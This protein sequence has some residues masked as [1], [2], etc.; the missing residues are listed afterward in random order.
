MKKSNDISI[1]KI[2][3]SVNKAISDNITNNHSEID[4]GK[5]LIPVKGKRFINHQKILLTYSTHLDKTAFITYFTTKWP[6][7]SFIRIAHENGDSIN[8]YPHS[9]VLINFEKIIQ[10][11]NA[12]IYD[13][14]GIHPHIKAVL[15]KTHWCR[16][17]QYLT[18]EDPANSD[19]IILPEPNKIVAVWNQNNLQDAL[20]SCKISEANNVISLWNNKPEVKIERPPIELRRWQH[21][22]A[23]EIE[24]PYIVD[25]FDPSSSTNRNTE[26]S[27]DDGSDFSFPKK[28]LVGSLL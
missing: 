10:S 16:C 22:F 19:L 7:I 14:L 17:V 23:L 15:N 3:D 26:Y 5:D 25:S 4:L 9:H 1:L 8:P 18:K 13:F 21:N 6:S 27:E 12:R 28:K 20:K 11:S 2:Q 24:T